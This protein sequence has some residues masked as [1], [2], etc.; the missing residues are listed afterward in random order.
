MTLEQKLKGAKGIVHNLRKK[1][2]Q[3]EREAVQKPWRENG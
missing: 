2:F 1:E 3:A